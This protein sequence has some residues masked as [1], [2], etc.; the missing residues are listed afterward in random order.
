M[1]ENPPDAAPGPN[2][3]PSRKTTPPEIGNSLEET[4]RSWF[5]EAAWSAMS[6]AEKAKARKLVAGDDQ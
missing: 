4:C 5:G 3:E 1:A 6:E 2:K